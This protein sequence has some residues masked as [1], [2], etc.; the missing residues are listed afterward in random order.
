MGGD[1]PVA[2]L[3][4]AYGLGWVGLENDAFELALGMRSVPADGKSQGS[5][6]Q[7]AWEFLAGVRKMRRRR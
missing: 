7:S 2:R 1:V 5:I 3:S 6:Q 4:Q